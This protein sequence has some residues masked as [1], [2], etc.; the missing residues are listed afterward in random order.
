MSH[1]ETPSRRPLRFVL[2]TV[3]LIIL[4]FIVTLVEADPQPTELAIVS[5]LLPLGIFLLSLASYLICVYHRDGT[6]LLLLLV[7]I[8]LAFA[9][10]AALWFANPAVPRLEPLV[11]L[12]ALDAAFLGFLTTSSG[13][14][15]LSINL[16]AM[17]NNRLGITISMNMKEGENDKDNMSDKQATT[18]NS[19]QQNGT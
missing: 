13:R 11:T 16:E 10:S 17:D 15:R 18:A 14:G 7:M 9:L 8:S 2:Y 4:A 5:F 19:E 3:L 1:T 12:L 6:V